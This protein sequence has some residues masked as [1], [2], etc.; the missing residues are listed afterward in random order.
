[1]RVLDAEQYYQTLVKE[2]PKAKKRIVLAAMV[3]VWG[4]RTA[5]IFV[6]LR[7]AVAR[8]VKVTILLDN[9]TRL[10]FLYNLRP[11]SSRTERVK[12]TFE[13]LEEL[14]KL[15]AKVHCFGKVGLV[16]YKGRCHA[17]LVVIDNT[18]LSFGGVNFLDQN[19]A[20]TDLMLAGTSPKLADHLVELVTQIG[21]RTPPL[22]DR[23]FKVNA[24]NTVL[25]DGGR[26]EQ[27]LIYE[28]AC[29]LTAQADKVVYVSLMTPSGPLAKLLKETKSEVYYNRPEQLINPDAWGQAFDEQR[30]RVLNRYKRPG[31]LHAKFMLFELP[32]GRK[33]I[34]SGSHNFSYRGVA[35]GTQELALHST[36]PL[37]WKR[38]Y[39]YLE[40]N[41]S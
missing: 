14:S 1:M 9:Y 32:A 15:G 12:R 24:K 7:D 6:M 36:D 35:Y 23:E 28:R 10:A 27:S 37:L 13:T 26:S 41:I 34:L 30:F 18:S 17:K 31:Y 19:F 5:P 3:V 8:G 21:S 38:L 39:T 25:F 40:K 20:N 11:K 2:I 22:L 4:E 16:P 33:A 29:E